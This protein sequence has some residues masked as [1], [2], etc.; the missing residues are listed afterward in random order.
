MKRDETQ[1]RKVQNILPPHLFDF[2][3]LIPLLFFHLRNLR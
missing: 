2:A 3:A 1:K